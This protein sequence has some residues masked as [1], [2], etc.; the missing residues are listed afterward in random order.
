MSGTVTV[1]MV[2]IFFAIWVIGSACSFYRII[3]LHTRFLKAMSQEQETQEKRIH[4]IMD[5]ITC[6]YKPEVKIKIIQTTLVSTPIIAGFF[7]PTIYLPDIPLSDG[8][9]YLILLHEWTHYLHKDL[10]IKL[11]IQIICA[12]YW[13]NPVIYVLKHNLNHTLE[14]KSDLNVTSK[15]SEESKF[16]YLETI[17]KIA[18]NLNEKEKVDAVPTVLELVTSNKGKG[19]KQRFY[20]ILDFKPKKS[21]QK[22]IATLFYSFTVILLVVSYLFIIQPNIEPP[23]S[24]RDNEI[25]RINPDNAY[26]IDNTN[27]TYSLY[28]DGQYILDIDDITLEP[29]S[30]LSIK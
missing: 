18:K 7:K 3:S 28:I 26:L 13:W 23:S 24:E 4:S 12:I 16:E 25:F 5:E 19:I 21:S 14:I 9:M 8:E 17:L 2:A 10:W 1:N 11:L 15:M 20:M 6:E 30:T 22:L 27:S 29:Y